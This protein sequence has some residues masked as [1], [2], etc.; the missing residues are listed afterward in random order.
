M[1][2]PSNSPNSGTDLRS[3]VDPAG[4]QAVVRSIRGNPE[5]FPVRETPDPSLVE[6]VEEPFESA[7]AVT[8]R[9]DQ[10]ESR[11]RDIE[12][13]RAVF[14]TIYVKMTR[15]V[16]QGI[17]AGDFAN[18][19]WMRAYLTAF[20]DE[21]RR[22]FLNYETGAIEQV[23]DP[24]HIA[25]GTSI[26][27]DGLYVQDAYLGVNAHINYDLALA[28]DRV[29]IDPDRGQKYADHQAINEILAE[30]IDAQQTALA[31]AYAPGVADADQAFGRW[32]ENATLWSMAMGR[33]QAW[34]VALALTDLD[35]RPVEKAARWLLRTT[36]TGIAL[37]ILEPTSR[38]GVR[39]QFER[40]ERSGLDLGTV[41]ETVDGV[42]QEEG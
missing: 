22:A 24:W 6:L 27:A 20:A 28:L 26:A 13:R 11:L 25:F 2:I 14:L 18:P 1:S 10:L 16:R 9:L 32:D 35:W 8:D 17:Q 30:L 23:P 4:R 38:E 5:R 40:M 42:I 39:R 3:I 36:A 19:S 12:D 37:G 21:Y 15:S 41:L 7:E 33:E 34:R 31:E 29:G